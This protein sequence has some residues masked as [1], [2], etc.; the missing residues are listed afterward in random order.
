MHAQDLHR[1]IANSTWAPIEALELDVVVAACLLAVARR[2]L[3][4][5]NMPSQSRAVVVL[6]FRWTSF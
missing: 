2:A 3:P 4:T 1:G 6:P 5:G